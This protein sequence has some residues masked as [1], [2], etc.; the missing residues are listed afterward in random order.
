M[1]LGTVVWSSW[2]FVPG[3]HRGRQT[4]VEVG[5]ICETHP[6]EAEGIVTR[7]CAEGRDWSAILGN[8]ALVQL[9]LVFLFDFLRNGHCLRHCLV[10]GKQELGRQPLLSSENAFNLECIEE[11]SFVDRFIFLLFL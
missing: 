4:S 11:S 7:S 8:V 9:L 6:G 5:R 1:C 3:F 2:N 10:V